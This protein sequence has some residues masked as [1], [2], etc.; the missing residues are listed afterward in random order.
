MLSEIKC[1]KFVSHGQQ[2]SSIKF[3]D[4][5][6]VIKGQNTGANSI[7]K[8]TSLLVI[9]FVFGGNTYAK[10]RVMIKHIGHHVIKFS[11]YFDNQPYYFSRNTKTPDLVNVCDSNY[12]ILET[13]SLSQYCEQLK[14]LYKINLPYGTFRELFGRYFRIYGRQSTDETDPLASYK[15]ESQEKSLIAFVKLFNCYDLIAELHNKIE[16][17]KKHKSAIVNA[18]N[19][20][21]V[22]LITKKSDYIANLE[23]IEQLENELVNLTNYGRQDIEELN[24]EQ[25]RE[26]AE[27]KNRF[28]SLNRLKKQLWAKYFR[29]KE[30]MEIKR[31][32]ANGGFDDLLRFFPST[33]LKLI[34]DIEHFH[35]R[36][37]DIL[38]IEFN[39]SISETLEK[40]NQISAEM[41][42]L[43]KILAEYELP[44]RVSKKTLLAFADVKKQL[45]DVKKENQLY[46][47]KKAI[48]IEIKELNHK[49][50]KLFIEQLEKIVKQLNALIK[51][52]NAYVSGADMMAPYLEIKKSNS[53]SYKTED[54]NGTGTN[55]I[56]LILLD[57]ASLQTSCLPVVVH[58]TIIFKHISQES[59]A[60]ILELYNGF[61]N[62]QV[63][64]AI[65]E[66]IKYPQ[67]A[68]YLIERNTVLQLSDNGNELY[69]R[70]WKRRE[71]KE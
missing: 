11:F 1:D 17:R 59:M 35:A 32:V 37:S 56:N 23:K 31:P 27:Y 45:D 58:D 53:Y 5:L 25:A 71:N 24:S 41:S 8:S 64:I 12:I 52:L 2:R 29:L 43:K 34:N 18:D 19:Y 47:E 65:D 60:R 46:D 50:E 49:Y 40:I 21:L 38:K 66:S 7:G 39:K 36:L 6:N 69:G 10:D 20:N 63:F 15:G 62:K 4:G 70:S 61:N 16:E 55:L 68:Q 28:D 22:K 13:I 44:Q 67:S 51:D 33:N 26:A 54:D 48:E 42:N 30:N 9:D 14:S 57:V 3:H